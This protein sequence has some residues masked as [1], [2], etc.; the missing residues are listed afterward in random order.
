M[1]KFAALLGFVAV[2][3]GLRAAEMLPVEQQVAEAIKS[4]KITV[5]HFWAPWCST[6]RSELA[7]GGWTAFLKAN[8]EVNAIFVTVWQGPD[9]DG[10]PILA[11]HGVGPQKNFQLVVHPNPSVF[12]DEKMTAFMGIPVHSI[13]ATWIFRESKLLYAL[14][15]GEMRF[16]VLQQLVQDGA[17]D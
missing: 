6:C 13:P 2:L 4:P 17:R 9:G 8:P 15:Y 11:K 3:A 5:V 16:P 1:R 7:S 10:R 12:N 14:N